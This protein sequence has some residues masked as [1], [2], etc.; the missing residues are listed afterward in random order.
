[1]QPF[2]VV[3]G[4]IQGASLIA[5]VILCALAILAFWPVARA[6]GAIPSPF[7][8]KCTTGSGAGQCLI[9]RGIAS[10]PD[11]GHVYVA[12]NTN[13]RI[14]EFTA[15]GA[16]IRTWGW[17]VVASG[18]DDDTA[19]PE[20]E[21]E[22]CV[23]ANGDLCKAGAEGSGS[24]QFVEPQGLTL[25]SGGDLYVADGPESKRRVQKFDPAAGPSE[26][27]VRFVLML[28][29][30]VNKTKV[31]ALAPEAQ[32]NICPVASGDVCQAATAGSGPGQ[33]EN[34]G[35]FGGYL[36]TNP[37]DGRIY[38][39]DRERIEVFEPDGTYVKSVLVPGEIVQSLTVDPVGDLYVSYL[40][41][42]KTIF[43]LAKPNAHK[44]SASG[45]SICTLEAKNPTAIATDPSGGV[46]VVDSRVFG[47]GEE[48]SLE[49]RQ[50]NSE[51]ADKGEPF[52]IGEID[53][54]AD[55]ATS[56]A[57][58][59]NGVDVYVSNAVFEDS[60]VKAYGPRPDPN[61]CPPP[62]HDPAVDAQYATS[63][64]PDNATVAAQINPHFWPDTRYYVEYGT[65]PCT[66]GTCAQKPVPPGTILKGADVEEDVSSGGIVLD[67]LEPNTTYHYR[68]VSQSSGGGPVF[69]IDPD[70]E[71]GPKEASF[72]EGLE[73]TFK[74]P[75]PPAP[76][77]VDCP[78]QAF[79]SG[80]SAHLTDCRAYEMVSPLDKNNGDIAVLGRLATPSYPAALE[81]GS[82]DGEKLTYTSAIAF[83]DAV[84][85]P[86][87][88]QYLATRKA[89]QEWSTHA[90]SPPQESI[91]TINAD[92]QYKWFSAD[93]CQGWL[94]Y[95]NVLQLAPGATPGNFNI[96]RR[97]NCEPAEG[98]YEA[99]TTGAPSGAGLFLPQLQGVSSDGAH[100][101]FT[102]EGG[103]AAGG[104]PDATQ[105]YEST[106]GALRL[107]CILPNGVPSA[108]NCA[109][110]TLN[111]IGFDGREN[112][113]ARAVSEDGSRVFWTAFS[114][115]AGPG[116]LYL[117]ENPDQ[118]PTA[119][120]ECSASEPEK[121]C[122]A[123]I[124]SAA[125]RFWT[126]ATDG[127]KAIY[128]VGDELL[129][130]DVEEGVARQIAAG[131]VGV[132]GA[133][134]DASRVYFSSTEVLSG[135]EENSE[136]EEAEAGEPN[137]YL[138][139]AGEGGGGGSF[140]FIATLAGNDVAIG[141][142]GSSLAA[143]TP[144]PM[145]R[146]ARVSA[147]GEHVAFPS[148]A[149]L[150][151]YDNTDAISGKADSEV[152]LYGADSDELACI[153]CNPS[154]ARPK[155]RDYEIRNKPQ[156]T[157]AAAQVP[158]WENQLFAPR[159]LSASGSRLFFE[160]FEALVPRDTNGAQDVYE[161]ERAA[162][163]EECKKAGG[164]LYVASAG[165]CLSLI[166]SGES[167]TDTEFADAGPN[168]RDVFIK[169]ASSLLP[170]DP[171]QVDIYDAREEGGL[172]IPPPAQP[173]CEGEACQSPPA[174]PEDPTPASSDYEGPGNE[175]AQPGK[176]RCPKSKRLVR[177]A[178]K[179]R[180]VPKHKQGQ[181]Q[182]QRGHHGGA[183]R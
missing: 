73:A 109:A 179:S 48:R 161:W 122:T 135:D 11:S 181:K 172:P 83:G 116:S 151:G 142:G 61:V 8:K 168:G 50:F 60:F 131:A 45:A 14:N 82:N 85:A 36:A 62:P 125:A 10:D 43:A 123:Q 167:P 138:Y 40:N 108:Q 120:G 146:A 94:L 145:R 111:T 166:S 126:A 160:S 105:L 128:T 7:W 101:F 78:N 66:G 74:T 124:S 99:V 13:N 156:G 89:G 81:Q 129:E 141:N 117:R 132:L 59:V 42:G 165:G 171:G 127:S 28:G 98:A 44:L 47:S 176:P 106:G 77:K 52:G 3:R 26:E 100:T 110:G 54:S 158:A 140:T 34:T 2:A 68:F 18:P 75:P 76:P 178:G 119:S 4:E 22:V 32:Q 55:I 180:C 46:Y 107:V 88:S 35:A 104:N 93:L 5:G 164:E 118:E 170:Q 67:K 92:L 157:W 121:A 153:S 70:G 154:G 41:V 25:D 49:V 183:G 79:R 84:G 137:L 149:S 23:P 87:N 144:D 163:E 27:E 169:T 114:N 113:V 9:P 33:F 112:T 162:G 136:G 37:V 38:V 95:E 102:A 72:A 182:A 31:E 19:A 56:A 175:K 90:I 97:Q 51:C 53:A 17:D 80:A 15:W 69:G 173:P 29:G 58:G 152:F 1:M 12:D 174:A 134:E 16:F 139:E 103:V 177:K 65:A 30:K 96:Y 91:T 143:I 24:G 57:C 130:Y 6:D 39:G 150:T 71:E 148:A 155:G 159:A 115:E 64:G 147:D 86:L 133:S 21:F 20:D 63:V